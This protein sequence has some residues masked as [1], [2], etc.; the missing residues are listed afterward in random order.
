MEVLE[1]VRRRNHPRVTTPRAPRGTLA[2]T[3]RTEQA[4]VRMPDG[5]LT[6]DVEL[7]ASG[8]GATEAAAQVRSP[9]T[10]A[11]PL[12]SVVTTARRKT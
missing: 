5:G 8:L 1:D 11:R 7:E 4:V 9:S 2:E 10:D 12:Q 6:V 3:L